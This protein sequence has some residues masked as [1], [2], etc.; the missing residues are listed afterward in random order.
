M[1]PVATA[2]VTVPV[3]VPEAGLSVNHAALSFA[4]QVKVPPPVLL[5]V[6]A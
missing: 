5:I 2:R 3:L 1:E 4:A 6:S